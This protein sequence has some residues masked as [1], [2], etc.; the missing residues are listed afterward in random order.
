MAA[1]ARV[2]LTAARIRYQP[3]LDVGAGSCGLESLIDGW[4]VGIDLSVADLAPGDGRVVGA[5]PTLPFRP[6]S[7]GSATCVSSLQYVVDAQAA[8]IDLHRVLRSGGQLLLLVPN[9]GYLGSRLKLARGSFPWSSSADSWSGGTVRY[10]TLKDTLALLD[11]V[12][13]V[14]RNVSCTGRLHR[15]RR[16]RPGLLGADLLFDLE[17]V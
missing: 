11:Q 2:P 8:I 10:F 4:Y 3:V 1:V 17:K 13:F 6:S 12:G 5:M 16:L 15:I 14:V 9:I 7:F